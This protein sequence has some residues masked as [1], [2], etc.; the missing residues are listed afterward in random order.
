MYKIIGGDG[1][2]Y[3]PYSLEDL[4]KLCIEG[5]ANAAT[6]VKPEAGGEWRPLSEL[7]EFADVLKDPSQLPSPTGA[8]IAAAGGI[9]S[10]NLGDISSEAW[11]LF[12]KNAGLL[13]GATAVMALIYAGLN[14]IP[15]VG[16][17]LSLFVGPIWTGLS[18]MSVKMVRGEPV[19]LN[20]AFAGFGPQFLALTLCG[21]VYQ[22]LVGIGLVL[23][24]IPGIYLGVSWTFPF[25]LIIDRNVPFWQAMEQSRK[26]VGRRWFWFLGAWIFVVVL[27]VLGAFA[28]LVGLL[29]ALPF[30]YNLFA[31]VYNRL[32]P[33][34]L[35][36][37]P[38]T[39]LAT[40][41]P[42]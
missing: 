22:I 19:S 5:R 29:V 12:K 1:T 17:I 24:I 28:C 27:L 8:I 11:A 30:V 41:P 10:L 21:I 39:P 14:L 35:P 38:S 13:I 42:Q 2:E 15:F 23:L 20:D 32:F 3:G 37:A 9:E 25:L 34:T 36:T 33:K 40:T 4:R 6:H 16:I 31:V 18:F 26:T 7:P